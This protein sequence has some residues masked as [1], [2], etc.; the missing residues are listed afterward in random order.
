M[1]VSWV[2]CLSCIAFAADGITPRQLSL[3]DP[4]RNRA[5]PV[6][7]YSE[8]APSKLAI[9]S[10]GYGGKNTAYSFIASY[11]AARGYL[12]ASIQHEIPGDEPLPTT[13]RP[14]EVRM[15]SWKRGVENILFVIGEVSKQHPELRQA[16]VLLVGHS[17]GGDTSMLLARDRPD[18]VDT[19]ISLDN[20]RMPIPRLSKPRIL[21]I[22]SSD[23]PPDEGVL[24]SEDEQKTFGIRVVTLTATKHDEM[25]DGA[26]ESQK[27]EILRYIG[28]FTER[29]PSP[30]IR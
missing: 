11:L 20:R 4:S 19:V 9:V 17:H 22:R 15:P 18:L 3:A 21:T 6:A 24:P 25:W 16:P 1:W 5:I 13:G 26:T 23:Q 14:Y 2:S 10:H 8:A 28:E 7:L 29:R 30:L 12:V 27:A